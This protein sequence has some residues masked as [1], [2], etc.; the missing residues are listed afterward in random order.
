MKRIVILLMSLLPACALCAGPSPLATKDPVAGFSQPELTKRWWQ[1]ALSFERGNSPLSD[2][3][4][5]KCS[6]GQEGSI[7][8]LAGVFGSDPAQRTC[9]VPEG[10]T[11]FFPIIN[12]IFLPRDGAGNCA[13]S[14]RWARE[15]TDSP[16]ALFAELD[17]EP[18]PDLEKHRVASL[19]CFNAGEKTPGQPM[20]GPAASNGYWLAFAP[21]PK[22]RHKLHFGG[23]LPTLQQDMTYTLI[24]E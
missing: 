7:W 14:L 16:Q 17:G 11:L 4:G 5:A 6:M 23:T 3:S 8:Y 2:L 12:Y 9:H 19:G 22:G 20:I 24:V 13:D 10:R 15:A 18:V 1:W 21:L